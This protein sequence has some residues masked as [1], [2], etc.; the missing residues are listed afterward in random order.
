MAEIGLEAGAQLLKRLVLVAEEGEG[1]R[2]LVFLDIAR[3]EGG[4][5]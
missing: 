3:V 5:S 1:G 2:I 4:S